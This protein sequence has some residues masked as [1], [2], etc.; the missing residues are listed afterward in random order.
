MT[1]GI[2]YGTFTALIQGNATNV[3]LATSQF[4]NSERIAVAILAVINTIAL[5]PSL[6]GSKEE[7]L[8]AEILVQ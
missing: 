3:A 6:I 8:P 5:V 4:I 7:G 2:P 1:I